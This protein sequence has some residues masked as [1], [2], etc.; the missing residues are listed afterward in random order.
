MASTLI[1]AELPPDVDPTKARLAYGQRAIP[2]LDEEL[3]STDLHTQQKALMA[4]CDALHDPEK[5][6][7]AI[8]CSIVQSLKKLLSSKD[9]VVRM[10][11]TECKLIISGHSIGRQALIDVGAIKPLSKLFDDSCREVRVN[12]HKTMEMLSSIPLGAEAIVE[13]GLIG[14]LI[15]KLADDS[16]DDIKLLILDTLHRCMRVKHQEALECDAMAIFTSLLNSPDREIRAKAAMDVKELSFPT[17]GKDKACQEGTV[18]SLCRLLS[19]DFMDVKSQA[20]AALMVITITTHGK[21]LALDANALPRL[22][23]LL[24]EPSVELRLNALKA[25][26]T[27]SEAPKARSELLRS[28]TDIVELKNDPDSQAI[29]KAA[30]IAERTITWKP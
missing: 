25:L 20:C 17:A 12:T 3:N 6:S 5:I 8:E 4:L 16:T 14:V 1:S 10:K 2:K 22:L 24:K 30:Q 28:L 11:A 13:C 21:Y 26:T 19:D 23:K 18:A 7:T 27:L 29:R 9:A 15:K